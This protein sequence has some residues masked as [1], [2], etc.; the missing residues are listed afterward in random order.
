MCQKN[1]KHMRGIINYFPE[2]K[3][4]NQAKKSQEPLFPSFNHVRFFN[5]NKFYLKYPIKIT[6]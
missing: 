1:E 3:A 4:K 2:D 6:T 5:L